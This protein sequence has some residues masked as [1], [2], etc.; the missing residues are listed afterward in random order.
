LSIGNRSGINDTNMRFSEVSNSNIFPVLIAQLFLL[1]HMWVGPFVKELSESSIYH[2]SRK[3]LGKET[4]YLCFAFGNGEEDEGE[5]LVTPSKKPTES[6]VNGIFEAT[7]HFGDDE[8]D[9]ED[10]LVSPVKRNAQRKNNFQ[11]ILDSIGGK[12]GSHV[13]RVPVNQAKSMVSLS[14]FL[15]CAIPTF[16]HTFYHKLTIKGFVICN[17]HFSI[18]GAQFLEE[19]LAHC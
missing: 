15:Y 19:T 4:D 10:L 1:T 5:M 16:Y 18:I 2:C 14:S 17:L 7:F 9:K 11:H 8:E 3:E 6:N 12:H 13:D